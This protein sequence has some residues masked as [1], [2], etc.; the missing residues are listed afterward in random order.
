MGIFYEIVKNVLVI[1]I[2]A[3]FLELLLPEGRVKPFVR[4]AIGL[5]IL[6][7]VLNP[8]LS[9]L[10]NKNQNFNLDSWDYCINIDQSDEIME[11]GQ[12]IRNRLLNNDNDK[13]KEKLQGQ[14]S[15]VAM[16]VPG[17]QGV[18]SQAQ[19]SE[20]GVLEKLSL[21][22]TTEEGD[23]SKSNIKEAF[24]AGKELSNEEKQQIEKKVINVVQNL[25]SLENIEI[26]IEFK[27]G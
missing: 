19:L 7:A 20:E 12:N 21:L 27:G 3:S 24:S 11:N 23:I 6:I 4:F 10:F 2:V 14:I 25:Y 26:E 8:T 22:I 9:F 15:A 1:I 18:E 17:V 16:L 13:V 5:F